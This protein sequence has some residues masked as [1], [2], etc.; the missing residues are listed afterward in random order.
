MPYVLWPFKK[1]Q[2]PGHVLKTT[3]FSAFQHQVDNNI[4]YLHLCSGKNIC[5]L[6]DTEGRGHF[7]P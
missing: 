4:K 1:M 7:S 6:M 5:E 2:L 3:L